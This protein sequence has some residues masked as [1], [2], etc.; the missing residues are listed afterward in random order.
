LK[1][2]M[3]ARSLMRCTRSGEPKGKA[4]TRRWRPGAMSSE[5]PRTASSLHPCGSR[6]KEGECGAARRKRRSGR[7]WTS[8]STDTS[9]SALP[10]TGSTRFSKRVRVQDNRPSSTHGN[11]PRQTSSSS[12]GSRHRRAHLIVANPIHRGNLLSAYSSPRLSLP[13]GLP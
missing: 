6:G 10:V 5:E 13:Q 3:R 11:H 9:E 12:S 1:G 4:A 2:R 7:I 8:T